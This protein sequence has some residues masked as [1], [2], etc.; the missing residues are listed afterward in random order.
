MQT[1]IDYWAPP[2]GFTHPG[3]FPRVHPGVHPQ[4]ALEVLPPGVQDDDPGRWLA[5]RYTGVGASDVSTLLGLNRHGAAMEVYEEKRGVIPMVDEVEA[6]DGSEAAEW[7]T[8][9]EPVVRRKFSRKVR[10]TITKPGTFRSVRWPWLLVN[11]DGLVQNPPGR[12]PVADG[13]GPIEAYEGK[14][15]SVYVADQWRDGQLPDHAELQCQ[16][17]M[18]VLGYDGMHV[19]CLI[20]GQRMVTRYVARDEGLIADIVDLTEEFWHDH[21][22]AGVPP[23]PDG[24]VACAE[25]LTRRYRHAHAGTHAV[26]PA[27]QAAFIRAAYAQE[28]AADTYVKG[29]L[30]GKNTARALIGDNEELID[31]D[32][33]VVATWRHTGKLDLD[34]LAAAHP[35]EVAQHIV[36]RDVFDEAAFAGAH[37]DLHTNHRARVLLVKKRPPARRTAQPTTG[38]EN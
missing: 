20:G 30:L 32:G 11:P 21:V 7:G 29:G 13:A 28:R 23:P 4:D 17:V 6:E 31:P 8:A 5:Y 16:T 33:E 19:A 37:P 35:D 38:Q 14:T 15:A 24:G 26:A 18:A 25:F 27:E 1:V 34:A 3:G 9:L 22:L 36:K 2:P 10:L 12:W